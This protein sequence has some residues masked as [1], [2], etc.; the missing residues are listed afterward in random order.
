[1]DIRDNNQVAEVLDKAGKDM[2][3]VTALV[4]G[5]GVLEDKLIAE[6][7]PEQFLTVFDTKV[8]GLDALLDAVDEK[9]IKYLVMFSSIA[10]RLGN[11]G[12]C[13]Y[14]VANGDEIN[15]PP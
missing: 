11:P 3:P 5:A 10:A 12:Q 1:M 14:A 13:D 4:H 6:K 8:K 2:G 9:R 15:A 7:T